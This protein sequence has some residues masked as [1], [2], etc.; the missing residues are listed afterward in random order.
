M[1]S[2]S[3]EDF[4]HTFWTLCGGWLSLVTFLMQA[5]FVSV[6]CLLVTSSLVQLNDQE[7]DQLLSLHIGACM[8]SFR[9]LVHM[10][11]L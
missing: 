11:S 5:R 4:G 6:T 10:T 9:L 7:L 3:A 1:H 8:V 2:V